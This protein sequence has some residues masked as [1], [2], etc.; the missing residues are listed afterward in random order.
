MADKTGYIGRNPSDSSVIVSQQIFTP[1]GSQT[2]FTFASTYTVGYLDVYVNGVRMVTGNDYNATDGSTVTLTSAAGLG[3]IVEIIAYK[4]F[5]LANDKVGILSES[6]NM[7][8][9]K[10]LNFLGVGNTFLLNNDTMDITI[11]GTAGSNTTYD[12]ITSTSGSNVQLLLDAST[13]DDDPILI[14]AGSNITLTEDGSG[15]GFTIAASGDTDTTYDLISSTSGSDI[16]L[17]LDASSG[18]DD[19]ITIT[20]GANITLTEDGSGTGFTIAASGGGNGV[21]VQDEGVALSSL[22]TTLNF[23]GSGVVASG[24]GATKT[25]TVSGGGGAASQ[26]TVADES[27]DT[28]CFPVFTTAATGDLGPKTG[29]NLTFNSSTGNLGATLLTGTLQTAAQANI[30]SVGTLSSLL[31]SGDMGLGTNSPTNISNYSSLTLNGATGGNIEFKDDNTLLGSVYNLADQFIVQ[32]QGATTPLAFRTNSNERLR[33]DSDGN[34][35]IGTTSAATNSQITLRSASPHLSLYG[36]PGSNTSQ[37]NLG[38]TDDHD[39]GNISYNHGDNSMRFTTNASEALRITSGGDVSIVADSKKLLIG[40]GDDLQLYHDGSDSYIQDAGTGILAILGS[41]VRIQNAGGSENCAKFIQNGSVELYHDNSKKLETTATGTQVTGSL[42]G[43]EDLQGYY[44]GSTVTYT[45]TVASK[46]GLHRYNGTGSGNG[47]QIDGA[48]APWLT[49]T[50]GRTYRFDQSDNTN[51][52]HPIRFYLE[53][54]RTTEYTTNVTNTGSSP[55]PGNSGAYT[56]ITVT[57]STPQVLY[58]MCSNHAY[59]GNGV[60]TNSVSYTSGSISNSDIDVRIRDGGTSLGGG[61]GQSARW[62]KVGNMVHLWGNA[63]C[64]AGAGGNTNIVALAI[65]DTNLPAIVANNR[66]PFSTIVG[67][68]K[69]NAAGNFS[70]MVGCYAKG[71]STGT[72]AG[73]REFLLYVETQLSTHSLETHSKVCTVEDVGISAFNFDIWYECAL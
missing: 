55:S 59:M 6:V 52:G 1:T 26:I 24:T 70:N 30:T 16:V 9:V 8:S 18:D 36:T 28:T 38:D 35:I 67:S 73:S 23:V 7:G 40:S 63:T 32:A 2:D 17:T 61:S 20:A 51:S 71:P 43:F 62:V 11:E 41:E 14:T 66:Q 68:P 29:S 37:L 50:P 27:S 54:D 19:P 48:F 13:G 57:D 42:T 72:T 46:N 21:T 34:V 3:D 69:F 5:N 58:Y 15:T 45:V 10:K 60:S 25:I 39:I 33:I 31:V 65:L 12:L 53:A 56:E 47:Y 64:S 49:L 22:G 44:T 4:A